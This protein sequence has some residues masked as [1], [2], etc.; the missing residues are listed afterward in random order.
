MLT[1][2][3]GMQ[4]N[5]NND[6]KELK[7]KQLRRGQYEVVLFRFHWLINFAAIISHSG[8]SPSK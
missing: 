1:N 2:Q 3:V 7:I 5:K 8:I 4:K 6:I